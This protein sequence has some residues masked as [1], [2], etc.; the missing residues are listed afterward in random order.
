MSI[1]QSDLKMEQ[2]HKEIPNLL[3]EH[4]LSKNYTCRSNDVIGQQEAHGSSPPQFV[5]H[6]EENNSTQISNEI[7]GGD[8]I[9]HRWVLAYKVHSNEPVDEAACHWL[10]LEPLTFGTFTNHGVTAT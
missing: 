5:W 3:D 8:A 4:S 7:V 10:V 2:A 1:A 6:P 9:V